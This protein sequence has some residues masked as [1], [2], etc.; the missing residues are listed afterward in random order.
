[1]AQAAAVGTMLN[2]GLRREYG[3]PPPFAELPLRGTVLETEVGQREVALG[4]YTSVCGTTAPRYCPGGFE[5][6]QR[7]VALGD[8]PSVTDNSGR[9][10]AEHSRISRRPKDIRFF[11]S[12]LIV[13]LGKVRAAQN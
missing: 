4:D 9:A 11:P 10:A 12:Q 6:G 5:V 3:A 8:Y 2:F 1:M 13:K 7:A